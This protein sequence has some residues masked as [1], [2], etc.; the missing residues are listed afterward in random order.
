MVPF[1]ELDTAE[2]ENGAAG[3]KIAASEGEAVERS[4][5]IG[6]VVDNLLDDLQG[7]RRGLDH[8]V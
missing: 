8:G 5:V 6:G 1:M 7:E 4:D 3:T 2:E